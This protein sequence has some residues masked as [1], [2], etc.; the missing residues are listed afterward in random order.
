MVA[1]GYNQKYGIDYDET[2]SPV[3]RFESVRA[4]I[5]LAAKRRLRLHQLDVK[6]AF[7]NG[8]L[9]EEIYMNQP[10]GFAAKSKENLVCKLK[11]SIYGLKQSSRC[12]NEALSEHLKKLGLKQSSHDPCIYVSNSGGEIIIAVY[13]DDIIIAGKTEEVIKKNVWN[14]QYI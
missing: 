10:D 5:A 13:V 6:T 7:L 4:L 12:W 1:Q 11:K 3:V 8:E 14:S 9:K 2:F